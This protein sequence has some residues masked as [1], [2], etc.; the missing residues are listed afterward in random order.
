MTTEEKLKLCVEFIEKIERKDIE[1]PRWCQFDDGYADYAQAASEK[2][3]HVL[4]ELAE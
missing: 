4:A 2:A 1:I 3:W